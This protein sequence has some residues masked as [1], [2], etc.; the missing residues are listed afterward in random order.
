MLMT[1]EQIREAMA[2]GELVI[3]GFEEKCLQGTSYDARIGRE[4]HVSHCEESV[5]FTDTKKSVTLKPGEFALLVTHEKFRF[6]MDIAANI[7]PKTYF[8]RK[9]LILLAGLQIDP[10]FSGALGLAVYNS[11]PKGIVLEHLQEIC[12]V[13]FF[14]LNSPATKAPPVIR[15]LQEGRLPRVDKDYF[16]DEFETQS[17][18]E[19]GKELRQLVQNV[20]QL[21]QNVSALSKSVSNLQKIGWPLAVSVV[22]A[23]LAMAYKLIAG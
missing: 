18:T 7:G 20:D 22:L 9:G 23:L 6:P 10:G 8:T 1:D 19:I 16:R 21:T 4:V 5:V 2:R 15:E 12:T 17:L 11:S 13:Q 3:E 14:R